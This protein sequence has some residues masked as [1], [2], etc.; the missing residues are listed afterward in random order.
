MKLQPEDKALAG[1]LRAASLEA[2]S[3]LVSRARVASAMHAHFAALAEAAP[4]P[5]ARNLR[6]VW[7]LQA[8]QL[9]DAAETAA[10]EQAALA[11]LEAET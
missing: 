5:T 9:T 4:T 2:S 11:A 1:Q 6:E 8:Q 10:A 7:K 3:A